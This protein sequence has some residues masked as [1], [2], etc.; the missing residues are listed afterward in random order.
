MHVISYDDEYYIRYRYRYSCI[1]NISYWLVALDKADFKEEFSVWRPLSFSSAR[2]LDSW[3]SSISLKH[4]NKGIK[5]M[6][7][8][9]TKLT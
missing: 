4:K 3:I 8:V 2:R 7:G 1:V 5:E 9:Q 6:L